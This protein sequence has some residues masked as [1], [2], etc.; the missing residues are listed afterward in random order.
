[1]TSILKF[2]LIKYSSFMSHFERMYYGTELLHLNNHMYRHLPILTSIKKLTRYG[3]VLT[4]AHT[5][6][7]NWISSFSDGPAFTSPQDF[8]NLCKKYHV[9]VKIYLR[10]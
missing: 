3:S 10:K 6:H 1:M 5:V 4:I 2:T 8:I 7:K 9:C